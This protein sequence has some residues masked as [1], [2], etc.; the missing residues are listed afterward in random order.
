MAVEASTIVDELSNKMER[1]RNRGYSDSAMAAMKLIIIEKLA[2]GVAKTVICRDLG[3]S[4]KTMKAWRLVDADFES[5]CQ[6]SENLG[7]SALAEGLLTLHV[8]HL[9]P[10]MAKVQAD[11]TKW[12]LAV[13][14]RS[15][16]GTK[17]EVSDTSSAGLVDVLKAAIARIPLPAAQVLTPLEVQPICDL[18]MIEEAQP[19][20]MADIFGD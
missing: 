4:P 7:N 20:T 13:R 14:D 2:E 15:T 11:N 18:A 1:A 12:L 16:Y 3:L 19:L 17:V 9:N 6:T 10:A 8:D 5:E